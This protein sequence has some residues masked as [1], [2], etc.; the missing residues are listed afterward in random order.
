MRKRMAKI[1][2]SVLA[3]GIVSSGF[4]LSAHTKSVD[5]SAKTNVILQSIEKQLVDLNQQIADMDRQMHTL[6]Q[7]E[8][9]R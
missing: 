2:I 1:A 4:A 7:I 3:V 8:A 5:T 9:N 6:T